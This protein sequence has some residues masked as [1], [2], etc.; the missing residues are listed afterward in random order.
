MRGILI[1]SVA[2]MHAQPAALLVGESLEHLIVQ[3]DKGAKQPF[4]GVQLHRE[5]RF[6][7][8]NLDVI[9][10]GG[11]TT[12]NVRFMFVEQVSYERSARISREGRLRIEQAEGRSRNDRL[13]QW[14]ARVP[15][16]VVVEGRRFHLVAKRAAGELRQLAR[17]PVSKGDHDS[18]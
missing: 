3:A 6:R 5:P 14:Q 17:V 13:L 18:I 16:C 9:G 4:A 8:I 10:A 1:A 2:G 15:S 12:A 7:E 11:Q